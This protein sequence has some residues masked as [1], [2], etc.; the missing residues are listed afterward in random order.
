M[1]H[2]VADRTAKQCCAAAGL[3]V[4]LVPALAASSVRPDVVLPPVL[5]QDAPARAVYAA[6][7][8]GRSPAPAAEAFV[9]APREAATA[10]PGAM[11]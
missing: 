4:A 2:V 7:E 1:A 6:T 11:A 10:I 9:A 8:R 3:G 5:D